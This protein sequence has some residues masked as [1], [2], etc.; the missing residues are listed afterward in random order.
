ML[1]NPPF[2]VEWKPEEDFIRKEHDEQDFG[3]RFGAG[4]PRI[5]DGSFL[6]LQHMISKMKDPKD[7]GSRLSIVFNGSPLF[8]GFAGSGEKRNPPLD[9]RERLV[10]RY[11]HSAGSAFLQYGIFTYLWILTNRKEKHR[12]G[13]IQLVDATSFF[14]KMRNGLGNKR[15]AVSGTA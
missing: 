12:K 5:N 9:Y 2:G 7:G 1:A 8:T 15:K 10:G 14:Q 6:F 4:L 13:K 3:G 11:S